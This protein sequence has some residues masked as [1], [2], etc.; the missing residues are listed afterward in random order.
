MTTRT[1]LD[2]DP[3]TEKAVDRLA[4]DPV[5]RR[6]FLKMVGGAGAVGA[7]G[8]LLAACGDD[9]GESAGST[10]AAAT[11]TTAA[12]VG[13]PPA[14]FGEGDLGIVNYALTLEH[15]EADFYAQVMKSGIFAGTK[16]AKYAATLK[17]IGEHEAA[18]VVALRKV[19]E[20]LGTA[21]PVPKT[22]F[23]A[24][25]DMGP[26]AVA[27]LAANVENLGAAAYLGQA[28]N[29]QSPEILAAALAIHSVEARH[30]AALNLVVGNDLK[31]GP[32]AG[33]EG[34]VP[35]VYFGILPDGAFAVGASAED[36]LAL[37]TPFITG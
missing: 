2:P 28:A 36:V 1:P 37:A 13:A 5:A 33:A 35:D 9:D 29:I 31:G 14:S 6:K 7:F 18:H 23:M 12:P 3:G 11:T 10:S 19:A 30:A 20:G 8:L 34:A 21:A 27:G 26:D 25:F 17:M 16:Y 4:N 15:I 24:V 22:D 32:G